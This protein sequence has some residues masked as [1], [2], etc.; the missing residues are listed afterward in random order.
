MQPTSSK[1]KAP[2]NRE[3]PKRKKCI[4][5]AGDNNQSICQDDNKSDVDSE[6]D[7][8]TATLSM[9]HEHCKCV[10]SLQDTV[11]S[12]KDEIATITSKMVSSQR[13]ESELKEDIVKERSRRDF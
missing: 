5:V 10:E 2:A 1:R 8:E 7:E 11:E 9:Q 12:L 4:D 13:K 3:P 6:F